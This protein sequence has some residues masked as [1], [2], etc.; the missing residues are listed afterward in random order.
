[1]ANLSL[2]FCSRQRR[3]GR[4]GIPTRNE[5]RALWNRR[6]LFIA[7]KFLPRP[8]CGLEDFS[9]GRNVKILLYRFVG[10]AG[11]P[12]VASAGLGESSPGPE[13]FADSLG[14]GRRIS[15][16]PGPLGL[17]YGD[18]AEEYPGPAEGR[19]RQRKAAGEANQLRERS[20]AGLS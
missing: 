2:M 12:A 6:R 8:S 18:L 20:V 9:G 17:E 3:S 7:V 16:R 11:E 15:E 4:E 19:G 1:M 10:R 13:L 14:G 5:L